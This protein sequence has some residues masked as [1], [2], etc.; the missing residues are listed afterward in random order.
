[1]NLVYL[2]VGADPHYSKLTEYCIN[3]IRCYPENHKHDII[4]MCDAEYAHN[5]K[6]IPARI[7]ITPPNM[8]AMQ[9]SMRKTEIFSVP[10]IEKYDKILYLDSD[11]VVSGALDAIFSVVND[12]TK[13]YVKPDGGNHTEVWWSRPDAPYDAETLGRFKAHNICSFNCGQFA[14][15]NSPEMRRHFDN[16]V[17]E[18]KRVFD[19]RIHFYEQVFMNNYFCFNEAIRYDMA[20]MCRVF[21]LNE[22]HDVTSAIVNHFANV[23]CPSTRK[24]AQMRTFNKDVEMIDVII[25][26]PGHSMCAEYVQSLMKTVQVLN[27]RKIT[28]TFTNAYSSLVHHARELTATGTSRGRN[29]DPSER[30]PLGDASYKKIIWIDSDIS[31]EPEDFMRLYRSEE[32]I[33]T[34]VYLLADGSMTTCMSAEHPGGIPTPVLRKMSGVHQIQKTGFGFIAV[35]YGVFEKIPRPWFTCMPVEVAPGVVDT[36]SEDISWCMKAQQ[37]GFKIYMDSE[38]RVGHMKTRRVGV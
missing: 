13:L 19:P 22:A 4:V 9:T 10:G 8:T 32:K 21:T 18:M 33:V 5:L 20:P 12:P 11:I 31:W 30:G 28:W 16:V 1:M 34:G 37:A 27:A 15:K 14:F 17:Q 26:T 6:G 36:V 2:V 24:L 7:H 29:L 23:N 3:T 25:A 35:K 38:V